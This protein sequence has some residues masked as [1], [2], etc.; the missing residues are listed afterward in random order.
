MRVRHSQIAEA[1]TKTFDW[2]FVSRSSSVDPRARFKFID[3]LQADNGIYWVSGK[4]GSGKSTLLKLLCD[5]PRTREALTI[6]AQGK[7]LLTASFFFWNAGTELQKSQEGLLQSLLYEIMRQCPA[8]IPVI[9]PSRWSARGAAHLG[10]LDPWSRV[11]L[12][13]TFERLKEQRVIPARFCFFIDGLDE[14]D[15]DHID[16]I[17]IVRDLAECPDI[18]ICLSSRPWNVFQAAFGDDR[19]RTL[20]LEELTQDDIK[21]YVQS[22]LEGNALFL[23]LRE[24]DPRYQNLVQEIVEKAKGVFLWVFLV[25]RSLLKGITNSDRISELQM[26]LRLLP[27]DLEKYFQHILDSTDEVYRES[28]AQTF[29]I[30]LEADEPLSLFTYSFLDELAP[31]YAIQA[32][33][34]ALSAPEILL[35]FRD[36][37]KRLNA[38]CNG[39]L[40][41]T[42][43][44][45]IRANDG[46]DEEFTQNLHVWDDAKF[47]KK[48]GTF[49]SDDDLFLT[50]RVDFLHRT[51]RDFLRTKDIQNLLM[52]RTGSDFRPNVHLCLAF[53]GQIKALSLTESFLASGPFSDLVEDL[54]FY[55]RQEELSSE[56]PQTRTLDEFSRVIHPYLHFP[57]LALRKLNRA[58]QAVRARRGIVQTLTKDPFLGFMVQNGLCLYVKQKLDQTL[59][60]SL[61]DTSLVDFALRPCVSVKHP[62]QGYSPEMVRLLLSR[63]QIREKWVQE[64]CLGCPRR[65][66]GEFLSCVLACWAAASEKARKAEVEI[67]QLLLR[68]GSNPNERSPN[69]VLWASLLFEMIYV[70]VDGDDDSKRIT[71]NWTICQVAEVFLTHGANPNEM[72]KILPQPSTVW[73]MFLRQAI[74]KNGALHDQQLRLHLVEQFLRHGADLKCRDIR[75]E[76]RNFSVVEAMQL[77]LPPEEFARLKGQFFVARNRRFAPLRNKLRRRR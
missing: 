40:E 60:N 42:T 4:P 69:G 6:W 57:D 16:I 52:D 1:H 30:A 41:V 45:N 2:M 10:S 76:D 61:I 59:W 70:C 56:E 26:R 50:Y 51:V 37:R 27:G 32:P 5:S 47:L 12:K 7:E 14:F 9:A 34:R 68:T 58:E 18:K 15:G 19:E 77:I 63:E 28:A 20:L 48:L 38:R 67:M 25:V 49:Q 31:D 64:Q 29:R 43:F 13:S 17:N 36:I 54:I 3:W 73:S 46:D 65:P 75:V 39:L 23:L 66:W 8:L 55:A 22:K 62:Q 11:E 21:F 35:R 71:S 53:L 24:K 33:V 74:C 72:Y 44:E